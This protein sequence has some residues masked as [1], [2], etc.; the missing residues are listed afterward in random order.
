MF[1]IPKLNIPKQLF[2]RNPMQRPSAP[3][4]QP[5]P[6]ARDQQPA[7]PPFF[8]GPFGEQ[9]ARVPQPAPQP[10]TGLSGLGMFSNFRPLMQ[11]PNAQPQPQPAMSLSGLGMFSNFRP[12]MQNPNAQQMPTASQSGSMGGMFS[13]FGP[14]MR[15]P[16]A[17]QMPAAGLGGFFG[18]PLIR[19]QQM[20]TASQGNYPGPVPQSTLMSD[21]DAASMAASFPKGMPPMPM[22][23]FFGNPV[24][25]AQQMPNFGSATGIS[26]PQG[27]GL[28]GLGPQNPMQTPPPS[29]Q[30]IQN[31]MSTNFAAGMTPGMGFPAAPVQ[32]NSAAFHSTGFNWFF[33]V[34]SFF[35]PTK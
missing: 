17:Q 29:P 20:P 8:T 26:A 16:N 34:K 3:Q 21:A 33:Y 4:P 14:L 18:N 5:Q 32:G 1:K 10:A 25:R 9:I 19:A 31:T 6:I 24:I 28:F 2:A 23:G 15:N 27:S 12:L 35:F 30:D 13:N 22:G 7:Q 11:N